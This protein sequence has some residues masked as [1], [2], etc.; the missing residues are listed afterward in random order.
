MQVSEVYLLQNLFTN[1]SVYKE[2][3]S[4]L[5]FMGTRSMGNYPANSGDCYP[6]NFIQMFVMNDHG[7]ILPKQT[8]MCR[9]QNPLLSEWSL[10]CAS[11]PSV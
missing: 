7:R 11:S 10:D 2:E 4:D 9:S 3:T 1:K 5:T 6:G 8:V